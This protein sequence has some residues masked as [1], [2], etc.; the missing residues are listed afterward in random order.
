MRKNGILAASIEAKRR[1]I[2]A[3]EPSNMKEHDG[4][5]FTRKRSLFLGRLLTIV[6]RCSP[7]SLQIRLDDYYKEIGYRREVVTKQAFSKARTKLDPEVVRDSFRITAQTLCSCEDLELYREKYLLC[8]IDGSTVAL[9]NAKELLEHFGGSGSKKDC[10][11][12]LS[13]LCYD[14]LNNIILD[15][16]L[17]PYGTSERD[18]A[19]KHFEEVEKL[20]LPNGVKPLYLHDRGYPS[21]EILAE[22]IDADR[23]FLMRVRKKFNTDFDLSCRNE[24]V[25]FKHGGKRYEVRVFKVILES[26]EEEIL[27]TNLR[28][29]HLSRK[30]VGE[31]YFKRWGIE[32]KFDS[33]KNKLELEN[34]SGRRV[35]TT[36]QDFWAKLDL[37]NTLAA[38]EYATDEA[39]DAKTANSNNRYK[40]TTNKNRLITKFTERYIEILT[41]AE[42]DVRL[43]A[44]EE[45]IKDIS[46]HPVEVKP[47]RKCERKPPRKKKFCDRRKRALA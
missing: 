44:F 41:I 7:N 13:S 26:G 16:G 21:K 42:D 27:I 19:R 34:F 36:Y 29:Q 22:M 32:V 20:P 46:R 39:I 28:A 45:L 6:L 18:A 9:D 3:L 8:A 24:K 11:T 14:P 5:S 35:C 38:L 40:Q 2:E 25:V 10:A 17:Y 33:L 47:N 43:M 23:C 12:A 15:G 4:K 31:L 30:E 37:A 1:F